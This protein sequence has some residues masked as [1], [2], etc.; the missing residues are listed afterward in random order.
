MISTRILLP[1]LS[2][3]LL[4]APASAAEPQPQTIQLQPPKSESTIHALPLDPATGELTPEG[5]QQLAKMIQ[6]N[7]RAINMTNLGQIGGV[8]KIAVLFTRPI[9]PPAPTPGSAPA[10]PAPRQPVTVAPPQPPSPA[11]EA[12]TAKNL[13]A[14]QTGPD[15]KTTASGLRYREITPGFGKKPTAADTVKVRYTGVKTDGTVFDASDRH[16][17]TAEFPLAHVIKGWT[18]GLQLMSEGAVYHFV[19]PPELAYGNHA[20]GNIG[21]DQTLLF[22]VELISVTPAK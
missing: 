8:P 20:P 1:T 2:A 21:Q 5:Q 11:K 6:E 13:L 3:L 10:A 16:G 7:W 19:I 22:E 14:S 15:L 4:L 9:P 12:A 17:G 18:E